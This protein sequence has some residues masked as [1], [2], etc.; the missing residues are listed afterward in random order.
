MAGRGDLPPSQ[1]G[2]AMK[3]LR[4]EKGMTQ[5]EVADAAELH[6]NTVAK[7]ERGDQEPNWP[8]VLRLA[9]VMGVDCRAFQAEDVTAEKEPDPPAEEPQPGSPVVRR[10]GKKK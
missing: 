1:F 2:A 5:K 9:E 3:R 4:T 8:L 10:E 6:P 7:L